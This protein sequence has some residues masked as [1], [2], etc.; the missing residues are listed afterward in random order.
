[1]VTAAVEPVAGPL[2]G[3]C[4]DWGD[5]TLV[6]PGCPGTEPFGVIPSGDQEQCGGLGAHAVE[7][8]Q[9]RCADG[10]GR[11]DEVVQALDLAV[12]ELAAP[13]R[14]RQGEPGGIAPS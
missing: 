6:G 11:D 1:V 4:G 8:G 5:A 2:A 7:G 3:R 10:H 14:F 13:S 9:A 12:Q